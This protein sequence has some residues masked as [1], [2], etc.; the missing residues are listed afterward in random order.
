[1]SKAVEHFK[2]GASWIKDHLNIITK[3]D[4]QAMEER[5]SK[6]IVQ[7]ADPTKLKDLE[8]QLRM[9]EDKLEAAIKAASIGPDVAASKQSPNEK[10]K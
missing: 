7:A 2:S 8:K 10:D 1:M 9:S 4:L 6:L 5:L 3:H